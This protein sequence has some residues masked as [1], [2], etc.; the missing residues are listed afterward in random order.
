MFNYEQAF[1]DAVE[2]VKLEK[3]YR[4]FTQ[5]RY[6]AGKAPRA[7]AP[8]LQKEITVWCSNDY[9]GM[10]QH[11]V[12]VEACINTVKAIGVGAGGTRNI[13]GTH[14]PIANLERELASLH[15]KESALVFTSGY[16]ANQA[17]LSTLAKIIPN[18]II[19]SDADN[20][21]SIIHGIRESRLQKH[22]FRH[23]DMDHLEI[24][25]RQYDL[26]VPKIIVFESVYS[27]TGSTVPLVRIRQ[28]A[29]KYNAL[30]YIDEVHSVGMYGK[31][32]AGIVSLLDEQVD[33]IQGTL[34]KAYGVIGGYIAGTKNVVDAI[35]SLASG[36]IF[37]TALPPSIAAAALASVR[38]LRKSEVE[39]QK[40]HHNAR[41]LKEGLR[42]IQAPLL[43]NETH[44]VPLLIGNPEKAREMQHLLLNKYSIYVQAINYP[45]VPRGRERLRI[46]PSPMHTEQM[47]TDLIKAIDSCYKDIQ[48]H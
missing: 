7:Y 28:L 3:R 1:T 18:C 32:G 17:S 38:Y 8:E 21:A 27:M 31:E 39:R 4:T 47:I 44:I 24:L 6:I 41:L 37:T 10:S 22:V 9:L 2:Q 36:F 35:R 42:K 23:N 43:E 33:I 29:Q 16:I 15:R 30:T 12:V 11:P 19:F 46:T 14:E 5:L 20:H 25:L 40:L 26:T 45:T 13:S 34:A 48:K